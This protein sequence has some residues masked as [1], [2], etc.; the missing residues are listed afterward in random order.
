MKCESAERDGVHRTMGMTKIDVG[1]TPFGIHPLVVEVPMQLGQYRT[2]TLDDRSHH[3]M[4]S[5]TDNRIIQPKPYRMRPR[6][7]AMMATTRIDIIVTRIT[8]EN[9]TVQKDTTT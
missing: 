2:V 4:Q 8:I 6:F 5:G 7:F 9:V 3:P 1:N